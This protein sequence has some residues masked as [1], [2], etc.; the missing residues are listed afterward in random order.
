MLIVTTSVIW[1]IQ[2][3]FF[4]T[5][6]ITIHQATEKVESLYDGVVESIEEDDDIFYITITKA[7]VT[8]QVQL[9]A[10]SGDVIRLTKENRTN[11]T[12][13][14]GNIKTKEAI[15]AQLEKERNG[16]IQSITYQNNNGQPFYFVE[17]TENERLKTLTIDGKSGKVI[18]ENINSPSDKNNTQTIISE[19]KARHLVLNEMKGEVT[20]I[21]Y[22]E[23]A[24]GGYYLVN[25]ENDIHSSTFQIHG[26]SG[27]I[28][29][30]TKH[31]NDD[32]DDDDD[33]EDDEQEE[34]D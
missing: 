27:K 10:E 6:D 30:V 1:L 32:D 15:R 23:T 21:L 25:I 2:E 11:Q 13:T 16:T 22:E 33:I 9:D 20:S 14:T 31:Q 18:S 8:F 12:E 5:E 28:L 17:I 7:N 34:D 4:N 3:R 29:S 19:A 26:V 24:D